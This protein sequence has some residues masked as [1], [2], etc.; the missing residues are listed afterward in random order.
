MK[1]AVDTFRVL[2]QFSEIK[3]YLGQV[4]SAADAHK[5]A[6]GFLPSRV[7]EEFARK[8]CIYVL[9]VDM[10][11]GTR[12]AGHLIFSQSYPTAK[13]IQ[14]FVDPDFRRNRAA[15]FLL[16]KF[17]SVLADAGFTSI[18][19]G[20]AEDLTV[21]NA[22][23]ERQQFYVQR[24]K[25]GGEA[26]KRVI[27]YRCHELDSPQLFPRSGLDK[28][29]PLGLQSLSIG[30][31]LLFLLDLNIVFDLTGPR[32][33]RHSKAVGLF[34]AERS[35]LCKLAVSDELRAELRQTATPGRTDPMEGFIDILPEV[36]L[37][38]YASIEPLLAELRKIVFP[39]KEELSRN[40]K[41]DLRHIATAIQHGLAGLITNDEAI[42]S[43]SRSIREKYGIEL[44][45]PD[46]F[47]ATRIEPQN[48]AFEGKENVELRI[49][50][51]DSQHS[52]EVHSFLKSQEI[53]TSQIAAAWLPTGLSTLVAMRFGVWAGQELVGYI[54]WSNAL[55]ATTVTARMV[56]KKDHATAT[57]AGRVM[58]SLLIDQLPENTSA[59]RIDL[60][61]PMSLPAVRETAITLGFRGTPG[62]TGLYKVALGGVL[63]EQT[64]AEHRERLARN[65]SIRLPDKIP[66]FHS[67]DQ[68]VSVVG[69]D[70]D[71]RFI[72]LDELESL[73]SP[74]LLCLPNRPA[75]ITPIQRGY[76]EPLLGHSAQASLLPS[77][78]ASLFNDRHY[79]CSPANLKHFKRGTLI[80]FYESTRRG[81]RA[82]L[83]AMARVRQAYLKH[84]TDLDFEEFE[85]SVLNDKTIG[86]VGTSELKTVVIFD[87][88]F[89]LHREVP[90]GALK[91]F[92]CGS[93]TKLLTTNPISDAQTQAILQEA[94]S[95]V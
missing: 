95:N 4:C 50:S 25:K 10:L 5:E 80:F 6:L 62:Q 15:T 56:V 22:F 45:S 40:D 92:G 83:V 46:A 60:E 75:V 49:Y 39:E 20:V 76:A 16:D 69:P 34:Q 59:V 33:I 36:P 28:Y 82:A 77:P 23:W 9:V 65:S 86:A 89:V 37:C 55:A 1:M 66:K 13:I 51:V 52:E 24:V 85:H 91:N 67:P 30:S 81:G 47:L 79:M 7:Y 73:L 32:R 27:L 88:I 48:S 11:D 3:S 78:R 90:L 2:S 58:L 8:E 54:T 72:M 64:W 70:G 26:R 29:N 21:A 43:A 93:S 53:P 35:N 44:I 41:S 17:K 84:C 71:R 14:M 12:Y 74:T 87:N 68:Q 57:D 42:L 31:D 38:Q 61:L 63:T 19:A 18:Y 94:F